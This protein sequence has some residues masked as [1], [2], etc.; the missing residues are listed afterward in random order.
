[1]VHVNYFGVEGSVSKGKPLIPEDISNYVLT[2]HT[3]KQI[4][5]S[6]VFFL[7]L[8]FGFPTTPQII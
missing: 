5:I 3:L 2:K 6:Y 1:M 8:N 7:F 4:M